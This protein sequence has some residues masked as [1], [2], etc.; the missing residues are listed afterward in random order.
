[1]TSK[2]AKTTTAP[3]PPPVSSPSSPSPSS[4]AP[5]LGPSSSTASA[6]AAA[7]AAAGVWAPVECRS[8]GA[9]CVVASTAVATAPIDTGDADTVGDW[10]GIGAGEV[11]GRPGTYSDDVALSLNVPAVAVAVAVAAAAAPAP[12]AGEESPDAGLVPLSGLGKRTLK[13]VGLN[14]VDV[15]DRDDA[16]D[17]T[18]PDLREDPDEDLERVATHNQ[19]IFK[20]FFAHT[21]QQPTATRAVTTQRVETHTHT[22]IK[23]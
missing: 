22:Q 8:V 19:Y 23:A 2:K 1:M 15:A 14:S 11:Q 12:V 20:F 5:Q 21:P 13:F 6:A 10:V 4:P 9:E 16:N 3:F 18:V 7:A 17:K